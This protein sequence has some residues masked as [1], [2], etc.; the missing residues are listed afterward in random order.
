M[1]NQL[2]IHEQTDELRD[3]GSDLPPHELARW[4]EDENGRRRPM[5]VA[6]GHARW[7]ADFAPPAIGARVWVNMND[8]GPARVVGYFTQHGWLG[9]LA[10]LEAP[11]AW[12]KRQNN[13]NPR[14]HL[15]GAEILE[16]GDREAV[17]QRLG[18]LTEWKGRQLIRLESEDLKSYEREG[19]QK[20]IDRADE[21]IAVLCK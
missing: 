9:I 2:P 3:W 20:A 11:P 5:D 17:I 7:S 12:H 8:L 14:G 4:T 10:D 1:S 18:K 6:P 16:L 19:A 13:N 15:F 21:L